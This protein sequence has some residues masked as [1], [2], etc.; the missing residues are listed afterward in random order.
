MW[1][2]IKAAALSVCILATTTG[3]SCQYVFAG[4]SIPPLSAS[5]SASASNWMGGAQ[6]GYNWQRGSFV[7]GLEADIS[8][9]DLNSEM[10]TVLHGPDPIPFPLTAN[11]NA[12]INWY[13]TVRG[14]LGW[15]AG[16]VLFY[17]TGGLAYGRVDLN[18][19]VSA[20]LLFANA[21]TSEVRTGWVVGGGIEYMWRP[22]IIFSLGYQYVDLGTI[23]LADS[24][25]FGTLTQNA[26][27]HA[28]FSVVAAG[29]SWRFF[30]NDAARPGP[31]EGMYFGGHVGGA[32]GNDTNADYSFVPVLP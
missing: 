9:M 13:G 1:R 3:L 10:T 12:D 29:L 23:S 14:R 28:Q 17:G 15:T 7:Y 11:T 8:A 19:S 21:Q 6:F 18:S 22:N 25:A 32:W 16:P 4:I 31:W 24:A 5:N 2:P 26:S 30:P 27:A 20:G